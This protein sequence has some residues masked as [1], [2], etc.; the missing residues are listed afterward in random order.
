[1]KDGKL[2]YFHNFYSEN[3]FDI[4]KEETSWRNDRIKIFGKEVMQPRETAYYGNTEAVYTYSGLTMKPLEWTPTLLEIKSRVE[5]HTHQKFNSILLN[6]YRTGEDYMGWHA[7]NEK[8]LGINP[9][10]A[11]LSFGGVRK[12][13]LKH[14]IDKLLKIELILE[15]GSLVVMSGEIQKFWLHRIAPTKRPVPPRIN[16]TFRLIK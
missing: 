9:Y 8:E 14:R 16:L 12:F 13:Q 15:S 6:H 5:V 10:I 7:D 1:M 11:S 2:E 4:L 3:L